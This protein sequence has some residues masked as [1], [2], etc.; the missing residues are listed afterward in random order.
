MAGLL[1]RDTPVITDFFISYVTASA[2]KVQNY[3]PEGLS[4]IRL[5]KVSLA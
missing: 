2:S 3:V 1:L 5:A 4:H